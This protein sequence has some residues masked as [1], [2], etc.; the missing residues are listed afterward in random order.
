M[1]KPILLLLLIVS[2]AFRP[3]GFEL[4]N[5]IPF[6]TARTFTNDAIGNLYVIADNQ[7]LKFNSD[8]KPLQNYSDFRLGELRSVDEIG[9]A[10][11]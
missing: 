9:R 8:G 7:L 11:V 4:V 1:R 5:S 10:H 3:D 6:G 2:S